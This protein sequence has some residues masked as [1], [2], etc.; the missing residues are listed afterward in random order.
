MNED[1]CSKVKVHLKVYEF[2]V[3]TDVN[4]SKFRL[5]TY[6]TDNVNALILAFIT[7][8]ARYQVQIWV[9]ATFRYLCFYFQAVMD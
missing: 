6:S 8:R 4:V 3:P 5:N 2:N 9:K 1:L 7:Q